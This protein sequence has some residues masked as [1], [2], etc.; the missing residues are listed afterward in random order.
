MRLKFQRY[1]TIF[2]VFFSC[3]SVAGELPDLR[4]AALQ[5][6]TVNWELAHLKQQ[7]LDHKNG[8]NLIID[9]VASLS[10][11]RLGLTSDS[12]DLI[13][14][15]WLWA[16]KR[17]ADG[18]K[19]GFIPFSSQIGMVMKKRGIEISGYEDLKGKNIGVAGG[20]MNKGWVLLQAAAKESG[21]DLQQ[22]SK[23]QF[24]APP[25]LNQ[26]LKR[27][28]IDI[29]VTFWHYG[30]RL[31]V[32]A[33][34]SWVSLKQIMYD[35]GIKSRVP[36]LGY[37]FKQSLYLEKEKA[38][39]GFARA[40]SQT[41][42]QLNTNDEAWET[43]RPIMKVDSDE[44]F[45]AYVSGYRNGIPGPITPAQAEDA[46]RFYILIDSLNSHPTGQTLDKAIFVGLDR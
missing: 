6:G 45:K 8:F 26:A 33:Y 22:Q 19:L 21:I 3:F 16:G 40:I 28:Q 31:E 24:G 32:E 37:L 7:K 11:A 44:L 27:G 41:K 25:L 39:E 35:L 13:V 46:A 36:M 5:S 1:L 14:S 15:D 34:E 23:V 20:P 43:L 17:N 4:V 2:T 38:L 29:L 18:E 30:A 10:A 9:K 12:T 42:E